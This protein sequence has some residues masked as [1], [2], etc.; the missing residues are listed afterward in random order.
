[1]HPVSWAR[2]W[3]WGQPAC[4]ISPTDWSHV[5]D[6]ALMAGL[7]QPLHAAY[8]MCTA[9]N[10]NTSSRPACC[11]HTPPGPVC[12]MQYVGLV[13]HA[14][15]TLDTVLVWGIC[16]MWCPHRPS[17]M[18]QIQHAGLVCVPIPTGPGSSVEGWSNTDAACSAHPR[19]APFYVQPMPDR[20]CTTCGLQGQFQ[21]IL[22]CSRKHCRPND[23]ASWPGSSP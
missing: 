8:T 20:L 22:H 2:V 4:W 3:A 5:L 7:V 11:M 16:H 9:C 17:P 14:C 18:G 12:S 23:P 21:C 10:A 19:P 1:M 6:P 13:W 15:Y